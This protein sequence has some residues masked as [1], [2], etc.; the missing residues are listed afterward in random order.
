MSKKKQKSKETLTV[1]VNRLEHKVPFFDLNVPT[2]IY[3]REAASSVLLTPGDLVQVSLGKRKQRYYLEKV[4]ERVTEYF[5]GNIE[6]KTSRGRELFS[7]RI[8][9]KKSAVKI[10][11]V[12]KEDLKGARPKDKVKVKVVDW[13]L[14]QSGGVK[15]RVEEIL[16]QAGDHDVEMSGVVASFGLV[17]TFSKEVEDQ[18]SALARQEMSLSEREDFRKELTFT[19]DPDNAKDFDDAL[20]FRPLENGNYEIGIHIA[21][22]THF[23][24]K[25]DD[26]D[27]EA[28]RRATSV[29]LPDRVIPMLPEVLSNN[30]C[31]LRPH[32]D[33]LTFSAIF[34]MTPEAEVIKSRFGKAMIHSDHRLTYDQAR[35][36]LE[37][38][39]E[40][41]FPPELEKALKTLNILAKKLRSDRFKVGGIDFWTTEIKF[42][43]DDHNFPIAATSY[44]PKDSNRLVEDFMLLA[45][46]SVGKFIEESLAK[47]APQS[48]RVNRVHL[49]PEPRKL[50]D[51]LFYMKSLGVDTRG[52][53]LDNFASYI[54]GLSSQIDDLDRLAV[55]HRMAIRV[56]SK[57]TY[58]NEKPGHYGLGFRHYAHFTSPIRRYPD[59]ATH[60]ILG[61]CL[62]KQNNTYHQQTCEEDCL[63]YSTK[64][65]QAIDA[66]RLGN[67]YMQIR[68]LEDKVGQAFDA[69]IS[70]ITEWG[71]YAEILSNGCE[72]MIR[73]SAI[74]DDYYIFD[75]KTQSIK[76]RRS[77][78]RFQIGQHVTVRLVKVDVVSKQVD[79]EIVLG[80]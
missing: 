69:L 68:F 1:R 76:G 28:Y 17:E 34:E 74:A 43:L 2:P 48:G 62:H 72:G 55:V 73:I 46:R 37:D 32:E 57:A 7:V 30:L 5:V 79:M 4:L 26:I 15:V 27:Q 24:R 60:R 12:E 38:T 56:M 65:R 63:H 61:R 53:S 20:S 40:E 54:N 21:D 6:R 11:Y 70:G 9:R 50:E 52:V 22:V 80:S 3:Q 31:S 42:E 14:K 33:R 36:V 59:M 75:P 19:I 66:E 67:R 58:S 35:L 10:L 39:S 51:F 29:Y 8:D 41:A 49:P 13:S 44:E 25:G 47:T 64:E 78:K 45:N 23:V 18:A 77:E 71:L 16:G